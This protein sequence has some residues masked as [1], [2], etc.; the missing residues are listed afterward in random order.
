MVKQIKNLTKLLLRNYWGINELRF[1]KDKSKRTRFL[2]VAAGTGLLAVLYMV[3]V[4]VMTAAYINIGLSEILPAYMLTLTSVLILFFTI[5][6]AGNI[7]FQMQSYDVLIA[8]PLSPTAII[9]SRF[10]TMYINNMLLSLITFAPMTV[11]Y[12]LC[13]KPGLLFYVIMFL[14]VFLAPLL[15]MTVASAAGALVIA[16]SARTKHKT[17]VNTVLSLALV[18]GILAGSMLGNDL[19]AEQME[20]MMLQM[21]VVL[22]E[23]IKSI[24]PPAV[25]FTKALVDESFGC[26][27]LFAGISIGVFALFVWFVQWKFVAICSLLKVKEGKRNY[28]IHGLEQHSKMKALLV[29][30]LKHYFSSSVYVINTMIGYIMM[31]AVGVAVLFLGAESIDQMMGMPGMFSR[32]GAFIIAATGA[33]TTT[34]ASS[35]SME[36]K[37]YWI[38]QTMP[39]ST[40]MIIDSKILLNL[41]IAFP[42]Y[43]VTEICMML[44]CHFDPVQCVW[45]LVIPMVYI[46]LS[47]VVGLSMNLKFPVMNWENETAVVKQSMAVMLTMLINFIAYGIPIAVLIFATAINENVVRGAALIAV[48]LM[49]LFLY[50][51]SRKA[52]L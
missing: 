45:F 47:A 52:R 6:K 11:V 26:Y 22:S 17:L 29:R 37:Q 19:T 32:A 51:R 4:A 8:M 25:L 46:V 40:K 21:S 34:T 7:L 12:A 10:L 5:Y 9:V 18:I 31:V 3:Y 24:Y 36:G 27:L 33:I 43:L 50:D 48:I 2:L 39:V 16:I 44:A 1:S 13:I 20:E 38:L 35:I 15:P 30:E 42:F 49:T 41:L 14:T 28:T 23:Q